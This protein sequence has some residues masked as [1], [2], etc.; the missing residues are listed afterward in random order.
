MDSDA[1]YDSVD[2]DKTVI[3]KTMNKNQWCHHEKATVFWRLYMKNYN[4]FHG[5]QADLGNWNI[6]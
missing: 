6:I 5:A 2:T 4:M 3:A 1:I